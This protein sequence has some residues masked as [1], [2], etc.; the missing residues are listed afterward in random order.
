MGS[1]SKR[2]DNGGSGIFVQMLF[3]YMKY[4][5]VGGVAVALLLFVFLIW[6]QTKSGVISLVNTDVELLKSTFFGDKP[7]VYYCHE[8]GNL[9][10]IPKKLLDA[11][12]MSGN[13]YGLAILNCSQELPSG[14]DIWTRFKLKNDWNPSIFMTAPW[15]KPVQIPPRS[16]KEAKSIAE[17]TKYS[18][19]PKPIKVSSDKEFKDVCAFSAE[20]AIGNQ[21][22]LCFVVSK[23]AR[24][25][26][27]Q[28][29]MVTTMVEKFHK[30]R[31]LLVDAKVRRFA[32]ERSDMSSNPDTYAMRL[33]AVRN[34]THYLTM[35][36]AP[37]WTNIQAFV[38]NAVKVCQCVDNITLV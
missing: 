13:K 1:N 23:G 38:K 8:R 32:H 6:F 4:M 34:G 27:G 29:A 17:F 31:I 37:T 24:Y 30:N 9:D 36:D 28:D 22:P 10:Y 12:A 18:L 19:Q 3:R 20:K 5:I 2:T 16:L 11:H 7:F 35:P 26:D 15:A 25:A 14:K 21:S 33:T